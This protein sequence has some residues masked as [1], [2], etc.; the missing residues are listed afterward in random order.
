MTEA[1]FAILLVVIGILIF[2]SALF[3]GLETALFALQPHQLRR[4]QENHA[5]LAN[6]IQAF[7]DNPRRV[8]NVLLLGDGLVKV[9]LSFSVCSF[10]GEIRL[11]P[12]CRSGWPPPPFSPWSFF[13][14]I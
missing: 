11:P 3:S 7:S 12:V 9:P 1:V 10:S 5:G 6:F 2:L 14:A 4:L 8:L 13:F